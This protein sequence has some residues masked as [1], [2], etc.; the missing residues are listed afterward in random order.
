[1]SVLRLKKELWSLKKDIPEN[2]H[3]QPLKNNLFRWTAT[4]KGPDDTPYAGGVFKLSLHFPVDYPYRPPYVKF[5]TPVYHPNIDKEGNIC[6]DILKHGTSEDAW[7]PS[8][9]VVKILLSILI[10]LSEPNP[11]SALEVD[12]ARELVY[13]PKLFYARARDHTK[14][15]AV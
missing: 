4:L 3:A 1:M 10:L 9:N 5:E 14:K 13:N 8:Y 2:M 11:E 7:S 15:H 6:L 12:I